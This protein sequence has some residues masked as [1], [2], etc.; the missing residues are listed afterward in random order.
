M[1][2]L[3]EKLKSYFAGLRKRMECEKL[4][5]RW[6][7]SGYQEGAAVEHFRNQPKP[8]K[9]SQGSGQ[10]SPAGSLPRLLP[11]QTHAVLGV[12]AV[13]TLETDRQHE[14]GRGG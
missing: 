4:T 13:L 8:N 1:F 14:T 2:E 9:P 7:G 10:A 11:S 12:S 6:K 3:E 5:L